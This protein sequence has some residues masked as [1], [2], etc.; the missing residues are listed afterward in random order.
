VY[1]LANWIVDAAGMTLFAVFGIIVYRATIYSASA[2]AAFQS[3]SAWIV[4]TCLATPLHAYVVSRG[5]SSHSK[6]QV[7]IG[8][9]L[10]SSR[11][12]NNALCCSCASSSC[13]RWACSWPHATH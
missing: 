13:L 8:R 11:N 5:F 6:A 9:A 2:A 7:I 10:R 12:C 4:I 1:W 3:F